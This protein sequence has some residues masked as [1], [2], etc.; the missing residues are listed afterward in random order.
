[1]KPLGRPKKDGSGDSNK[2][3]RRKKQKERNRIEGAFG[4]TKEHYLLKKVRACSPETELS[5]I[6][7]GLMSHNLV[8]AARKI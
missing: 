4:V 8:T 6:Q 2:R 1:M 3:W 5:W 7:M